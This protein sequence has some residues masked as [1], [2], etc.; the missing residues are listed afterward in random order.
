MLRFIII[1]ILFASCANPKKL[2]K[3]MDKLPEAAAKECS[4]RF[5]IKETIQT[6][7]VVDSAL[8]EQYQ[9]EYN[10]M[11]YLVDSLLN[12]NCDTIQ[13]E[14][15]KYIINKIPCKPEIK[16]IT[17]IQENT[18]KL[19]VMQND[20]NKKINELSNVN[21]KNESIIQDLQRK[22][23]KQ[24]T[25]INWMWLIIVCLSIFAFRRQILK[26]II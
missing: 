16:V 1:I 23:I 9:I 10:Y 18:A 13:I 12:A 6:E 22:N 26:L 25:R 8:L 3:M 20:C 17:K 7:M 19:Q 5:P 2:H 24:K 14:K 11:A 21:A 15:I 4:D